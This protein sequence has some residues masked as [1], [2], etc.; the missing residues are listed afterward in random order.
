VRPCGI[1]AEVPTQGLADRKQGLA[2]N[3]EIRGW[4]GK[5]QAKAGRKRRPGRKP[6]N[7][8]PAVKKYLSEI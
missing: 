3:I 8:F 2:G 1:R 4:L 5:K 6:E 7:A